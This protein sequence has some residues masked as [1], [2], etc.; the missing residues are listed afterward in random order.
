MNIQKTYKSMYGNLYKNLRRNRFCLSGN[1][2][3]EENRE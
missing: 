1:E 2:N 3:E